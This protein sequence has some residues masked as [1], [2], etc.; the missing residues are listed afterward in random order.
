MIHAIN[1]KSKVNSVKN[2]IL[3]NMGAVDNYIKKT[4][5]KPSLII[6]TYHNIDYKENDYTRGLNVTTRPE[7]LKSHIKYL[8]KNFNIISLEEGIRLL[9]TGRLR[10]NSIAITFDDGYKST[11]TRAYPILKKHDIPF[12]IFLCKSSLEGS[13]PFRNQLAY[14]LNN[15]YAVR[16]AKKFRLSMKNPPIKGDLRSRIFSELFPTQN[17]EKFITKKYDQI[18]KYEK[19]KKKEDIFL[20]PDD[21][22]RMD[23]TYSDIGSHTVN[24]LILSKLSRNKQE[25]EILSNERYLISRFKKENLFFAYPFGGQKHFNDTTISI[26][27]KDKVC[28]GAVN[29]SQKGNLFLD[30]FNINRVGVNDE[31]YYHLIDKIIKACLI[32]QQKNEYESGNIKPVLIL[33]DSQSSCLSVIRSLG[34]KGMPLDLLTFEHSTLCAKSRYVDN[35]Y[36]F[37]EFAEWNYGWVGEFKKMLLEKEYGMIIPVGDRYAL[38]IWEKYSELKSITKILFPNDK[39]VRYTYFKDKTFRMAKNLKIPFPR[40]VII[41]DR[42]QAKRCLDNLQLRFPLI[43]KP[44]KSFVESEKKTSSNVGVYKV[45]DIDEMKERLYASLKF[46]PV[47]IQEYVY[48]QIIGQEF[49]VENGEILLGFQHLRVHQ[50]LSGGASSYRKSMEIN[51]KILGYSKKM[52]KFMDYTGPIMFEYKYL[53]ESEEKAKLIEINGRFWGS[54]PLSRFC[55][56]DFPYVAYKMFKDGDHKK[57]K[58]RAYKIRYA[59]DLSKDVL[60]FRENLFKRGSDSEYSYRISRYILEIKNLILGKEIVD[61]FDRHDL[62]PFL[63]EIRLLIRHNVTSGIKKIRLKSLL[64]RQRKALKGLK[65]DKIVFCCF[66]NICRSPFAERLAKIYLPNVKVISAGF[67]NEK[68][69][70][71]PIKF[72]HA[73]KQYEI[74]LNDHKSRILKDLRLWGKEILIVFDLDCYDLIKKEFPKF[75]DKTFLA[76]AFDAYDYEIL[77][78]YKKSYQNAVN[79]YDSIKRVILKMREYVV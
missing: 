35:T 63:E 62:T 3:S 24:H 16:I 36:F 75:V 78:P 79:T 44:I 15:G 8:R 53:P 26:L 10:R 57:S 71:C 19:I 52:L 76:S 47:L 41:K 42:L 69:R 46:T 28:L 50:P 55:G 14:V 74:D 66:G 70:K 67:Y 34:E 51:K 29:V 33:G 56:V 21:V 18:K 54:L 7:V 13:I 38:P 12:T 65:P 40:T 32:S 45:N 39:G 25:D 9:K 31:P 43:I 64:R 1:I 48:G 58:K 59:R 72:I 6:L 23:Q 61:T 11:L 4:Y 37:D 2:I 49:L 77:D 27:K 68:N 17:N 20:T 5:K 22:C 30:K 60:F 73:A